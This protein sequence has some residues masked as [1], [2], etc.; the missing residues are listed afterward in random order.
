MSEHLSPARSYRAKAA[1]P[2]RSTVSNWRALAMAMCLTIAP[3]TTAAETDLPTIS[4]RAADVDTEVVLDGVVEAV[5]RSTVSAQVS[6]RVVALPFDVDDFVTQGEVIV[7]FRDTEQKARVEGARANLEEARAQLERARSD[8]DR[9]LGLR[10]KNLVSSSQL[11]QVRAAFES[12]EARAEA[13]RAGLDEALE[14]LENTVVKAPFSG[15][16]TARHVEIGETATVGQPLMTGLS[17]EHLRVVAEVPQQHIGAL[18]SHQSARV[19]LPD[20]GSLPAEALRIFP[21]ASERTHTFR[22]RASLPEGRYGIYPGMLVKV[23]FVSG[24]RERLLV[25][26][27]AIVR[28]SEVT[29]VY[30][31]DE[32]DR[33]HF[34]QVRV[35]TAHQDGQVPVL[36]GLEVGESVVTDPVAAAMA[37]RNRGAAAE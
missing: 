25:P 29:A 3:A 1:A 37:H 12:A 18:R 22:V 31:L 36:A 34:R 33:V 15:I 10:E 19:I 5:N 11:D 23:A 32:N 17:L 16:V 21:Y 24:R 26:A 35:G 7:R 27:A 20:S 8:Y 6:A 14:A 2:A 9:Y 28:R 13:V 4:A 30:V